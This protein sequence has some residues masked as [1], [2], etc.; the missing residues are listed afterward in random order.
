MNFRSY[1]ILYSLDRFRGERTIFAIYH[2]LTGKKSSQTIQD[3]KLFNLT[4]LFNMLNDLSRNELLDIIIYLQEQGF[5]LKEAEH[6]Y[7]LTEKG[8]LALHQYGDMH[9]L[10][11]YLDGWKYSTIGKK[12]WSRFTLV[13]QTVSNLI[14]KSSNFVPITRDEESIRWAK[15]FLKKQR[16]RHDLATS[17]FRECKSIL[18]MISQKQAEIF[19]LRITSFN[20]VGLTFSQ[21]SDRYEMDKDELRLFFIGSI[22]FMVNQILSDP[23]SFPLLFEFVRDKKM[24]Y[25]IT[26]S[27]VQTR[28]LLKQGQSIS[29]IATIRNLK[30]STIEDHIVEIALNDPMFEIDSFVPISNQL[31]IKSAISETESKRLR[32]IRNYLKNEVTYFEI[33][34]V[35]AKG[36]YDNESGKT[37][38]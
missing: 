20:K 27:T 22:H 1:I 14:N 33:R 31:K 2:L 18:E 13:I 6:H 23:E 19:V 5:L 29:N 8:N 17:L 32:V 9:P 11:I 4:H 16:N 10:P 28:K 15:D 3:M 24:N 35:L 36:G 7:L 34:L 37:P 30:E 25:F 12:F 38:L 26:H 21:L